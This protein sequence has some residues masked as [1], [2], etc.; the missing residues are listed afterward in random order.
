MDS[1][2]HRLCLAATVL[3]LAAIA[4]PAGA[5]EEACHRL[6]GSNLDNGLP[7]PDRKSVV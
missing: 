7:A 3:A 2:G 5:G 1:T 6:A 4:L